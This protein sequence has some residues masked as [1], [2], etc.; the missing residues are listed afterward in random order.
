[1]LV[2]KHE[3]YDNGYKLE[4]ENWKEL[5]TIEVSYGF[6]EYVP[7][8][9]RY[10]HSPYP[11]RAIFVYWIWYLAPVVRLFLSIRDIYFSIPK[12]LYK[13]GYLKYEEGTVLHW[14]W[15][16]DVRLRI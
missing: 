5:F 12:H 8:S 14:Y 6:E 10:V 16:I 4:R 15:F 7:K 2:H 13:R 1:M 11:E 9:F 3:A